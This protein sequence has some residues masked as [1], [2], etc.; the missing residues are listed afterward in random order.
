LP[1]SSKAFF[2]PIVALVA[3]VLWA[4]S[5]LLGIERVQPFGGGLPGVLAQ[6]LDASDA[7]ESIVGETSET[8]EAD[9]EQATAPDSTEA[10][11]PQTTLS[12]TNQA[13]AAST[14]RGER[15]FVICGPDAAVERAIEE[16]IAGR[17]SFST[18]LSSRP[19][20][21]ADL[22]I[23]VDPRATAGATG[24]RQSSR[25]TVSAGGGP[26]ISVQIVSE[27]GVTRAVIGFAS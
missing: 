1:G 25:Q 24:G 21:C 4:C 7:A 22:T 16:L 2:V 27:N 12:P 6:Q 11:V 5:T 9:I 17:T 23:R 14:D 18:L 19:D 3:T 15:N 8:T 13:A 10:P 20:G 26:A